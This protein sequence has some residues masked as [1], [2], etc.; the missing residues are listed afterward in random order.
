MVELWTC[1]I[2]T[3]N[4]RLH[5]VIES[6][7]STCVYLCIQK[8]PTVDTTRA[9][10]RVTRTM[11]TA[12]EPAINNLIVPVRCKMYILFPGTAP[13]NETATQLNTD[14]NTPKWTKRAKRAL[15]CAQKLKFKK[16][17]TIQKTAKNSNQ[18][19]TPT[20]NFDSCNACLLRSCSSWLSY[21]TGWR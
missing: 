19:H 21:L 20:L 10:I 4:R 17:G 14:C 13:T 12:A 15:T 16:T 6:E 7:W 2:R 8:M 11:T 1:S 5:S 9:M 18:R 3:V